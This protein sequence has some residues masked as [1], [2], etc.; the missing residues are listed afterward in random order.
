MRPLRSVVRFVSIVLA[1]F[2]FLC[3]GSPA[4]AQSS[5]SAASC[6]LDPVHGKIKH[7]ISVV[8]DNTH[9]RRDNPNVPSDLE[10]MPNLLNFLR[11]NGTVDANHKAVLISHTADDILTYL[12]G[13][14]ADRHGIPVANSYGVFR[15]T[16]LVAFASSFFYWTDLVSNA[17][18]T[19]GDSTFGMLTENGKNA[20]AP[21]VPFT[22]A[23]CD[24]GA[25]S[26]ANIVIERTPFDVVK[27]F[28]PCTTSNPQ[29]PACED[30][31][32]QIADFEG[33]AVHCAQGSPLC[34]AANGAV[35]DLLPQEPGG[36]TGFNALIGAKFL[37][38]ALGAPV[39]DLDGN[40]IVNPDSGLIGFTGFT[41]TASQT[42]GYVATMQEAGIPVTFAYISDS[43]DNH[44]TDNAFGPGEAGYVA[45]LQTY[46]AAFAKFFARLAADGIDKSNTLFIFT[47]DEATTSRAAPQAPRT[48]MASIF[49]APTARSANLT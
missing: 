13:V 44:A 34:S 38:S 1:S 6:Q 28:G 27:V 2:A 23:G 11:Q 7:V 43:H 49:R 14:Y 48:A 41:P 29:A 21:W 33:V 5:G 36:Y 42:L 4:V 45:Q 8:F 24:F 20:P 22:R 35:A 18:P 26:T 46:D 32:H 9:L 31:N 3:S 16:G 19:S 25:F 37:I 40:V 47:S 10:Q 15:P 17:S 39:K 12:T 30:N